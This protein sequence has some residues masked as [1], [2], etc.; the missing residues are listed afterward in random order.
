MARP[1]SAA[2][3]GT[4]P[5]DDWRADQLINTIK[6][7]GHG[8]SIM[9]PF[10]DT[11]HIV[12]K[13]ADAWGMTAYGC[14]IKE[15]AARQAQDALGY[16]NAIYGD[17][18][19]A[20]NATN[21]GF[22]ILYLNPPYD[23][24]VSDTSGRSEMKALRHFWKYLDKGG[25]CIWV[26]YKHHITKHVAEHFF[27]KCSQV[28]PLY[29][30]EPHLGVYTQVCIIGVR[31]Q[32][33]K[34]PSFSPKT[35]ASASSHLVAVGNGT[36]PIEKSKFMEME[37]G[38]KGFKHK[39]MVGKIT[40][41]NKKTGEKKK[42]LD[43]RIAVKPNMAKIHFRRNKPDTELLAKLDREYGPQNSS[44]FDAAFRMTVLSDEDINPIA[45]PRAGQ[46][47][48][49]I[50]SGLLDNVI[51]R[52]EGRLCMI[53]GSTKRKVYTAKVETERDA[54]KNERKVETVHD[55]P[56]PTI[57]V[58]Y[59]DGEVANLT[60][61]NDLTEFISQHID[62][63]FDIYK[64]KYKPSYDMTIHPEWGSVFDNNLILG[65]H[66]YLPTQEHVSTAIAEELMRNRRMIF[67]GEMSFGKT[68]S[69]NAIMSIMSKFEKI[70]SSKS[71]REIV[72]RYGEKV[73]KWRGIKKDDINIVVCPANMPQKWL[74]EISTT[75]KNSFVSIVETVDDVSAFVS[76]FDKKIANGEDVIAVMIMSYERLKLGETIEPAYQIDWSK[77]GFEQYYDDQTHTMRMRH[78]MCVI[79]PATGGRLY[80]YIRGGAKSV[81][82][83]RIERSAQNYWY[84]GPVFSHNKTIERDNVNRYGRLIDDNSIIETIP[85]FF[86]ASKIPTSFDSHKHLPLPMW[87]QARRYGLPD[88]GN[89]I[90]ELEHEEIVVVRKPQKIAKYK[91]E[92]GKT[93]FDRWVDY[94]P[95]NIVINRVKVGDF[96]AP[97]RKPK[98]GEYTNPDKVKRY[99]NWLFRQ[100]IYCLER[101]G[102]GKRQN[103]DKI[104]EEHNIYF[105]RYGDGI[106]EVDKILKSMDVMYY[107]RSKGK[108]SFRNPRYPLGEFLKRRFSH[109]L[110]L[111]VFDEI[112]RTKAGST[113][114]GVFARK[115]ASGAGFVLGLTGTLYNGVASSIYP[116]SHQFSDWVKK[117]FPWVRATPMHWIKEM[118]AIET[119]YVE[120]R[121][122]SNGRYTGVQRHARTQN[123][124]IPSASPMIL[125]A[126]ID[127]TVFAGLA[128][129][130]SALPS[131]K[132]VPIEVKM[133]D[134]Q[135]AIYQEAHNFL[136]D[137]LASRLVKSDNSFTAAFASFMLQLPDSIFRENVC[138]HRRAKDP[139]VKE[140]EYGEE[141]IFQSASL[142]DTLM[143]KEKKMIELIQYHLD[144]GER[145]IVGMAQT[146][147]KDIRDRIQTVIEENVEQA[148]V[149]K[150]NTSVKP[151]KRTKHIQD[152][153]DEGFNVMLTNQRLVAEGVD[154]IQFSATINIEINPS[155]QVMSQFS[156]RTWRINQPRPSVIVYYLYYDDIYQNRATKLVADK[157]RAANTI[158]G[159]DDNELSSLAQTNA[160]FA[161]IKDMAKQASRVSEE[162]M[163]SA[164]QSSNY[165]DEEYINSSWFDD[166]PRKEYKFINRDAFSVVESEAEH[167]S[168]EEVEE[169]KPKK[170]KRRKKKVKPSEGVSIDQWL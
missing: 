60:E 79:D 75:V 2:K 140:K 71:A 119:I 128:D 124:E 49:I 150:L 130:G 99:D 138:I 154:L 51:L 91:E 152:K 122:D 167:I 25:L 34:S 45:K 98:Y 127:F 84:E 24:D 141:V 106:K 13:L 104:L 33:P 95:K 131:F 159:N 156:R 12:S 22:D 37:S 137:Y 132:E 48:V 26:A 163:Q 39:H 28:Y 27:S 30:S 112:H 78:K 103:I 169:D 66:E 105:Y 93:V 161:S 69:T 142:G 135:R 42:V 17:S 83:D 47:G 139:T 101:A 164:F 110:G 145:V 3:L 136:H 113:D 5:L 67:V 7:I 56:V 151:S 80:E 100:G 16:G 61:D 102:K 129:L 81:K 73:S 63:L 134:A 32:D 57:T 97:W 36:I 1:E 90:V 165:G 89:G 35:I 62:Q 166:N 120:S 64:D 148:M 118:G 144:R 40:I 8:G 20:I 160:F 115:L 123:K 162:E 43:T 82:K 38:L 15:E 55:I 53:R 76:D 50:A 168:S 85:Q 94:T 9:D 68:A 74:K 59:E 77:K 54:N 117:E 86:T 147:T 18:Y 19:S 21:F 72:G 31:G 116:I 58:I 125:K 70:R 88:R 14:E 109:R 44:D 29:W 96:V 6:N 121:Y 107:E 133:D 92:D 111:V 146:G 114:Q 126:I 65:A 155:L 108:V 153:V 52:H 11:G 157:N 41:K 10:M 87:Q 170:K 149:F 46:I 4:F 158:Y 23:S 143:P